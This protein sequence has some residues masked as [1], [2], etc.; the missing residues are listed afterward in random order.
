MYVPANPR[1]QRRPDLEAENVEA[2]W[3]ELHVHKRSILFGSIYRPPNA[4]TEALDNIV[5][6]L[7][8]VE[9]ENKEVVIMGELNCHM[10]GPNH[11]TAAKNLLLI[12][13]EHNLT[14]MI[15]E[16]TQIT[17]HSEFLIDLLLTTNP[18]IFASSSTAPLLGSDHLMIF[19]ECCRKVVLESTVSYVRNYKKCKLD[20]LLSD[21]GNALWQVVDTFDDI[22]NKWTYWKDLFLSVVADMHH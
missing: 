8:M 12:I 22:D 4:D 1:S 13:E 19:R 20:S 21:L 10:L 6:I 17:S 7:G 18:N 3:A 11:S 2:I 15:T 9:H 5:A 16:P 14:Q